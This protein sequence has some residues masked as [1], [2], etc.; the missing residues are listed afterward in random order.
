MPELML[1]RTVV[2]PLAQPAQQEVGSLATPGGAST[3]NSGAVRFMRTGSANVGAA[4]FTFEM[5]VRPSATDTDNGREGFVTAGANYSGT[6]GNIINDSDGF[7]TGQG[8]IAGIDTGRLYLSV[9]LNGGGAGNIRT[10]IGTT[11]LR[12]GNWHHV[13]WYHNASGGAMDIFVDGVRE[14]TGTQAGD[15]SYP[16]GGSPTD[17]ETVLGKEKLNL[18][19]GFDGD[20]SEVRVSTNRRYNGA[21]YSVPT[22]PFETDADT[23]ILCHLDEGTGTTA[24]DSS[25]DGNDGT[26][27]GNPVPTWSTDDPF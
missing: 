10:I 26:L 14:A 22:V 25:G 3:A 8:W 23:V 4:E 27:I 9:V 11:D 2:I 7:S 5:W 21:T 13:A 6:D 20:I 12:D 18:A 1:N 24:G 17:D 19:F 15:C 16:G